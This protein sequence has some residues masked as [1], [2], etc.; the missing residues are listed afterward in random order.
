MGAGAGGLMGRKD[1][2]G[3]GLFFGLGCGHAGRDLQLWL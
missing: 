3:H 2:L 1:F